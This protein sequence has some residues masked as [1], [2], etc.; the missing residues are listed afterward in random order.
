VYD[1][2]G[3]NVVE[4]PTTGFGA[5]TDDGSG[6]WTFT[7]ETSENLVNANEGTLRLEDIGD[8]E[9]SGGDLWCGEC[10]YSVGTNGIL[11]IPTGI[12]ALNGAGIGIDGDGQLQTLTGQPALANLQTIGF[13][14]SLGFSGGHSET[15]A[16]EDVAGRLYL[17]DT[18]QLSNA[19]GDG[20][21]SFGGM[22][23]LSEIDGTF[24]G[25]ATVPSQATLWGTGT[26]TG[27]LTNDGL[28]R[29]GEDAEPVALPGTLTVDGNYDQPSDGT[30]RID[31][32]GTAPGQYSVLQVDGN[33]T[34]AGML[35]L[36]PGT[37]YAASAAT[38]DT[39]PFAAYSGTLTGTLPS[40]G[41][42]PA[43]D[44]DRGAT[45]DTSTPGVVEAV[46]GAPGTYTPPAPANTAP[47]VVS[48]T[49]AQGQ[50][51]TTTT[52]TWAN[53]PVEYTYSWF[54]CQSTGVD[55]QQIAHATGSTYVP[56]AADVGDAIESAVTAINRY[57][58]STAYSS[59][60]AT[61]GPP[62]ATP[63]D[64]VTPV[65]PITPITPSTPLIPNAPP[66]PLAPALSATH[67]K[68]T[69][70]AVTLSEAA[71][72]K[73]AITAKKCHTTAKKSKKCTEALTFT[74]AAGANTFK[75]A[76]SRLKPGTY[77]ATLTA[78]A[79]GMTS[80]PVKLKL[81]IKAPKKK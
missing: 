18:S 56:T 54:D 66:A 29:P 2:T 58:T 1:G 78:T 75:L 60:T 14:A 21:T 67:L 42:N 28:V 62:L 57:G 51:L 80:A 69:S 55:C 71:S 47:P 9:L 16:L 17:W 77:T 74:G 20:T 49:P 25:N 70:L 33:A 22:N 61:V 64:P 73:V 12:V 35:D 76:I 11:Q 46:I 39:I 53:I 40:V 24:T 4:A 48:G 81:T 43:L 8:G 23:S 26:I 59:A 27:D 44:G 32:D 34:L 38:G 36:I 37:S 68:G 13:E 72:V 52:G 6:T 31:V 41:E 19:N 15:T 3:G 30:L 79:S 5:I 63:P 10:G 65:T 45:V 50:A 7:G